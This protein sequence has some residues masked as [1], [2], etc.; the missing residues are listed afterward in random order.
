MSSSRKREPNHGKSQEWEV[1]FRTPSPPSSPN[2][3][4]TIHF[5]SSSPVKVLTPERSGKVIISV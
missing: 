2:E 4:V 3:E 1:S 5:D